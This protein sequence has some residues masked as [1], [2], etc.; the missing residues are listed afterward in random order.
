[1]TS[2]ASTL[3]IFISSK[4]GDTFRKE[5]VAL[6]ESI[7]ACDQDL[8][9][10]LIRERFPL[11]RA[12]LLR[13]KA[14]HQLSAGEPA[15][16]IKTLQL[17]ENVKIEPDDA[18]YRRSFGLGID[19]VRAYAL[20]A[21]GE[22]TAARDLAR[23]MAAQRPYSSDIA[24]AAS[25]LLSRAGDRADAWG[26]M[27]AEA[28]LN[29]RL[30]DR[31]FMEA[32]DAGRLD[33]ALAIYPHLVPPRKYPEPPGY[34]FQI[35]MADL[36]NRAL[37]EAF[38]ASR[39]SLMALM[40]AQAGR[41]DAANAMLE[42][43]RA[44]ATMAANTAAPLTVNGK[45][46][47][48]KWLAEY[49]SN[50]NRKIDQETSAILDRTGRAMMALYADP[51]PLVE[52]RGAAKPLGSAE[53]ELTALLGT[54]PEVEIANRVPSYHAYSKS[55]FT[56][57]DGYTETP[58]PAKGVTRIAYRTMTGT[59]V[60]AEELAMLRAAEYALAQGKPG[61]IVL[62]RTDTRHTMAVSTYPGIPGQPAP[63]G[64]TVALDILPV[65]PS[66]LPEAH[67]NTPWRVIDAKAVVAALGAVYP[68]PAKKG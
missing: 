16:A 54:L 65:D 41:G 68:A 5:P 46:V 1:M 31:M 36:E 6:R 62:D 49:A 45:L 15:E 26:A 25:I 38:W 4:G 17:A 67:L 47:K 13:A 14:I 24:L 56:G 3:F 43:A 20:N 39:S 30:L 60:M 29:P 50:L 64:Y 34:N 21:A 7:E 58:D 22:R 33:D 61:L 18:Y 51:R 11:R 2:Y 9:D 19:A 37:G 57:L 28:R 23:K 44:R 52:A 63:D 32:A 59:G 35:L 48:G 12:S 27:Q 53:E 40:L 8:A 55:I 10:P 66:A 42:A